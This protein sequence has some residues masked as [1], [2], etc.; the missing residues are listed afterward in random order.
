MR[1]CGQN[2]GV[3]FFFPCSAGVGGASCV[4]GVG[5]STSPK[6][7]TTFFGIAWGAF[8]ITGVVL[9]TRKSLLSTSPDAGTVFFILSC[10]SCVRAAVSSGAVRGLFGVSGGSDLTGGVSQV[11]ASLCHRPSI[12]PSFTGDVGVRFGTTGLG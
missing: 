1:P 11:G 12:F 7:L 9:R 2:R 8:V 6:P 10:S 3:S 4:V 5:F